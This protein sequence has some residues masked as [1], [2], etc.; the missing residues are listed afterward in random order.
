MTIT[1][2]DLQAADFSRSDLTGV[3]FS[4]A[5]S[6]RAADFREANL[7]GADFS[8]QDLG[9]AIFKSSKNAASAK[10][11]RA[12]ILDAKFDQTDLTLA[13]YYPTDSEVM[14]RISG[15]GLEPSELTELGKF[16]CV[17]P[18]YHKQI[19]ERE[20]FD[21]VTRNKLTEKGLQH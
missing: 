11:D 3:D 10:F 8:G 19:L 6:V 9:P 7:A 21:G 18:D 15:L 13:N 20:L 4:T 1:G 12:N 16:I 2:A 5:K 14:H 17:N